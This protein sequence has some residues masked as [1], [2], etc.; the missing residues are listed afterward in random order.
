MPSRLS[1]TTVRDRTPRGENRFEPESS[2]GLKGM[3][4]SARVSSTMVK[5]SPSKMSMVAMGMP[6]VRGLRCGAGSADED[7][8]GEKRRM[9]GRDLALGRRA[10]EDEVVAVD[11]GGAAHDGDGGSIPT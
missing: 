6:P 8:L 7:A 11:D 10:R 5:A 4:S 1:I 9:G 2:A 3:F